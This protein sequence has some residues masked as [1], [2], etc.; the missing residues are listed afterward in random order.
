MTAAAGRRLVGSHA[1]GATA[2]SLPW[3][4]LLADVW[5]TTGSDAWLG[6][7]GAARLLPYVL[8]STAAGILADRVLRST[9]LRW[10]AAARTLL[11]AGAATALLAD[12]LVAA[13]VVAA[14]AVAVSTPAYPASAAALPGIA[15][16]RTGRLTD[17][18]VT[19]EVSAFMVGPAMGGVLLGLGIGDSAMPVAAALATG[20]W[21]LLRGLRCAPVPGDPTQPTG[22]RLAVVL[23]SPGVPAAIAVVSLHNFVEG[24]AGVALLSLSHEHWAAGDAGF[25]IGTAALGFG[26]LAA[27]L[28]AHALRMRAALAVSAAGLGL[29]GAL[30][31]VATAAGPLVVAGAAG[32]VVECASTEVLQRSVPDRVLAFSLGLSDAIMVLAA[33]LGALVA[34]W[35]AG[36]LGP[37]PLFVTLALALALASVGWA[38]AVSRRRAVGL[39]VVEDDPADMDAVHHQ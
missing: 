26:A 24:A 14:L 20:S 25:G 37:V 9:V 2:I 38:L 7:T 23:S 6:L 32:T 34:P 29:A 5:S 18:L 33:M 28:V 19:V 22:G 10:S 11:V 21:V 27:P 8:L 16:S 12:Q 13:V 39:P 35:L 36:A 3:P 17:L 31:A 15:G 30:P 4:L 1:L